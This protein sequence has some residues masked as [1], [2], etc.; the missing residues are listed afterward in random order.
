MTAGKFFS[1][2]IG[3]IG[4]ALLGFISL[5]VVAWFY[6]PEDI[7][8]VAMLQVAISFS[9]L[10][11]SLGLDQAYVREYHESSQ[12][13]ALLKV[14]VLPGL[15]LLLLAGIVSLF[16]SD[17]LA[18]LLFDV[19]DAEL[20]V[21][22]VVCIVAA[23][24]SRFLSLI[25]R[26]QERGYAFSLSQLLPKLLF[27]VAVCGFAF[28]GSG[29]GLYFLML[30][31]A[32]SIFLVALLLCWNVRADVRQAIS[33]Q[34]DFVKGLELLRFGAP[35]V[36]GGVSFWA[37]S[38]FDKVFL[39]HFSTFDQLGLYSVANS[40]ASA[41]VIFQSIFSTIWAPTVYKWV[42][43]GAGLDRIESVQRAVL[44]VVILLLC[45]A[46]LF[47]WVV[48]LLLP[49]SYEAAEYL[50][51]ACMVGPLFYTLSET[52]NVGL[53]ISRRSDFAM[54]A[55]LA[56]ALAC[57]GLN[58]LLVPVLGAKGAAISSAIT[59]WVLLIVRTELSVAVWRWFPRRMLYTFTS[60]IILMVTLFCIYGEIYSS[61]FFGVWAACF[62]IATWVF[63]R[64][65]AGLVSEVLGKPASP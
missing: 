3:P 43:Q 45:L 41:A 29:G 64:D 62:F 1:F 18:S 36:L 52:T 20:G 33:S 39:R 56:G 42:A 49:E 40:F 46:G 7:G 13:P 28:L 31:N 22:T 44:A 48:T 11:F 53:G 50:V 17:H 63:H 54:V 60:A 30:A 25:L 15:V 9:I 23:F 58:F 19:G 38:S 26:M 24:V 16:F 34:F 32:A 21:L 35:L 51:V 8:R 4:A 57:A 47:S 65:I 61:L 59:F 14:V 10:F 37:M 2:A 55:S 5:P 12:K 27:L 6:S